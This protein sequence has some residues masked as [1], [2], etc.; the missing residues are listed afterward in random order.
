[1]TFSYQNM[2]RL[3]DEQ[4]NHDGRC[5]SVKDSFVVLKIYD[6]EYDEHDSIMAERYILF[7]I[8]LRFSEA[9]STLP[10][11]PYGDPCGIAFKYGSYTRHLKMKHEVGWNFL[12]DKDKNTSFKEYD[13][14]DDENLKAGTI[15]LVHV[16]R[17][18]I[19]IY[20]LNHEL[21]IVDDR[22]RNVSKLKEGAKLSLKFEG[23]A[24][25]VKLQQDSETQNLLHV[26]TGDTEMRLDIQKL[27]D[28]QMKMSELGP[29]KVFS[30]R[31]KTG[32][33]WE[34]Q[35]V[36]IEQT[37][38]FDFKLSN[39]H[40][41][42]SRSNERIGF[43][44]KVFKKNQTPDALYNHGRS[45]CFELYANERQAQIV[46]YN[47]EE[48]EEEEKISDSEQSS[49]SPVSG[50][51]STSTVSEKNSTS[52]TEEDS[53][54]KDSTESDSDDFEER[55][56]WSDIE[57]AEAA[58]T[59]LEE[60]ESKAPKPN[61][62]GK[63]LC[64]KPRAACHVDFFKQNREL[65]MTWNPSQ[66]TLYVM[67]DPEI[68]GKRYSS[69]YPLDLKSYLKPKDDEVVRVGFFVEN[70]TKKTFH[71]STSAV[72]V[73]PDL[74]RTKVFW[75]ETEAVHP[76][77]D[78][79]LVFQVFDEYDVPILQTPLGLKVQ[80]WPI[81]D[82]DTDDSK[83]CSSSFVWKSDISAFKPPV[84]S[85]VEST[86]SFIKSPARGIVSAGATQNLNGV[87]RVSFRVPW[88][89]RYRIMVSHERLLSD[90]SDPD[91]VTVDEHVWVP[92]RCA[93]VFVRNYY[94]IS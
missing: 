24:F 76:M 26:P 7:D 19:H 43:C 5:L 48:E 84:F 4:D 79:E 92:V 38:M 83:P 87:Y 88:P 8:K 31:D 50:E 72:I 86:V 30:L 44:F 3:R 60:A 14:Y 25:V 93:H 9:A 78:F 32:V 90:M 37:S 94:D 51:S 46:S 11:D 33:F 91:F 66:K 20:V 16:E 58:K 27:E 52:A 53:E 55:K 10:D 6:P 73:L 77:T 69:K 39:F 17:K 13:S 35:P 59:I 12:I 40:P 80:L 63:M 23:L 81:D 61:H 18:M 29:I 15:L 67:V 85:P 82:D 45:V 34:D 42:I 22:Y 36:C 49:T 64:F 21:V 71:L 54:S 89:G 74:R 56:R 75:P 65:K 28:Y 2:M 1:M 62:G 47:T 70:F 57:A 68:N 41:I